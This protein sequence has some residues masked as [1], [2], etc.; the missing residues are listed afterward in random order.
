MAD[1]TGIQPRCLTSWT[2]KRTIR[3]RPVK[4]LALF[5]LLASTLATPVLAQSYVDQKRW[6]DA[7]ARYQREMD[8]YQQ[9]RDR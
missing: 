8:V 7:Q 5:A 9:E 3:R 4:T 6:D 2:H 1:S